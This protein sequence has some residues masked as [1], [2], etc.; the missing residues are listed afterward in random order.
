MNHFNIQKIINLAS[1]KKLILALL[2]D[3][4]II[5]ISVL[6][7]FFLTYG[8]WL[9]FDKGQLFILL[10]APIIALSLLSK[11]GLY[12]IIT[13]FFGFNNLWSVLKAISLYAFL[14][15]VLVF[16]VI[17]FRESLPFVLI[18]W[19]IVILGISASRL[20]FRW[21]L[22]DLNTINRKNV[23][24]YGAG[25]AGRQLM[26]ALKSSTEY[27]VSG[28]IDDSNDFIQ[29]TI[30]GTP[31]IS[32]FDLSDTIKSKKIQEVFLAMPSL[33]L[34]KRREIIQYLK[35]YQINIK[36]L[37]SLSK[38]ANGQVKV[39]HLSQLNISDLLGRTKVQ[40][41]VNLMDANT[42]SKAVMISGA[43]G[44][45]GS[46]LCR[47]I[48]LLKPSRLI[49]VD[50]SEPSL[51]LINEELRNFQLSID[52]IPIIASVRDK[53]RMQ[54]IINHFKVKTIYHAAA[55]KHVPMVE[56]NSTEGILN[57][58]IGT[59]NLAEIAIKENVDTFV[60]ISSDKAVRP[61]NVM[62][63]TKSLSEKI[64]SSL[65]KES[66]STNLSIVRF[67]N[68]LNSSGSVIPL[69]Q[70]QIEAG[71]PITLTNKNV[72]RYFMTLPESVELVIQSGALSRGNGEIFILDMG[73]PI[74]IYDLAVKMIELSGLTLFNKSTQIGDIEIV[75]TGLRP[76]EKLYEEMFHDESSEVTENKLILRANEVSESWN[77]LKPIIKDLENAAKAQDIYKSREILEKLIEDYVPEETI[78][79][80]LYN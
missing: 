74:L 39:S 77:N 62:G 29:K 69:F 37:P 11:F 57:N 60:L 21:I 44:S 26:A 4:L 14:F 32:K 45:I 35:Q 49:L 75:L 58:A 61:T 64:V 70:K 5:T 24:I 65:S 19:F 41:N 6:L 3:F 76:G 50:M 33:P 2:V 8:N 12:K 73:E 52:V 31:L 43:G 15:A 48:I 42:K 28:F 66:Q 71:G 56:Y 55:Y 1:S 67:G 38:I 23:L 36:T 34:Y 22:I 53:V 7:S 40:P 30:D 9:T 63:A 13:R 54:K 78:V 68:V 18:N 51:Y 25:I 47:Q 79:D 17:G 20:I 72:I 16:M 80:Y 59:M 27:K 46:E 10:I